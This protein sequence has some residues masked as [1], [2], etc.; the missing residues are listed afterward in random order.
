M[1]FKDT[2]ATTFPPGTASR[3]LGNGKLL[4]LYATDLFPATARIPEVC[5][6]GPSMFDVLQQVP[7]VVRSANDR[8][9]SVS[10]ATSYPLCVCCEVQPPRSSRY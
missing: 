3:Q 2:L 4:G 9:S 6:G 8:L 7:V 5:K 1:T 10:D